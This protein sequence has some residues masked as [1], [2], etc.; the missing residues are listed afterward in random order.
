MSVHE[1]RHTCATLMYLEGIDL[2]K[3][4]YWLGH[5]N[6]ST[7]ANIYAHYDNSKDLEVIKVLEEA[8]EKKID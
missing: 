3:I 1:L 7:T 8:L 4:Q 6:I 2:K 5:S